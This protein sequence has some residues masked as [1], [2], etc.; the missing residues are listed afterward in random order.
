LRIVSLLYDP[1]GMLTNA[2]QTREGSETFLARS[3]FS[4]V[5]HPFETVLAEMCS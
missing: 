3:D 5:I 1:A 2:L 4:P